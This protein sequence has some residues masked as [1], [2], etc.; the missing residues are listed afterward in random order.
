MRSKTRKRYHHGNLRQALIDIAVRVVAKH[1]I[2]ALNLRQLA[3]LAGVTAGAPYYHFANRKALLSAIAEQGF[4]RFEADLKAERQAA[5][6][7]PSARLEALGRAYVQS[8]ITRPGYFRVMFHRESSSSGATQAGL[9][10]FQ[11]L[12]DTIVDCQRSGLAPAGDP[13]PLVL[14]AW[15]AVHGLATLWVDAALP[16]EGLNPDRLAPEVGHL[17]VR[18]F[19]ALANRSPTE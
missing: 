11:L 14:T 10:A 8:A 6:P 18:M 2:D 12:R 9:R 5:G 15:S 4:L 3:A 13:D 1:G 19:I 16:F 17:L 7:D